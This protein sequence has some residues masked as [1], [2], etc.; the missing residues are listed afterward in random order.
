MKQV[1]LILS[2]TFIVLGCNDKNIKY[3]LPKFNFDEEMKYDVVNSEL[4]L[5]SLILFMDVYKDYLVM[6]YIDKTDDNSWLHIHDKKTGEIIK[7]N[8]L[9]G[10]GPNEILR[11]ES[12]HF[13]HDTGEFSTYIRERS[14][15]MMIQIDSMLAD[16]FE[17]RFKCDS[18]FGLANIEAVCP[19]G[20]NRFVIRFDDVDGYE[21]KRLLMYE[22]GEISGRIDDYPIE[23]RSLTRILYGFSKLPISPDNTKFALGTSSGAILELFDIADG[24]KRTSIGYYYEPIVASDGINVDD[25]A[26][27][28]GFIDLASDDKYVYCA[29]GEPKS[30]TLNNITIFDWS[31]K[32]VKILRTQDYEAMYPIALDR[33]TG[34][35]YTIARAEDGE[36]HIIRIYPF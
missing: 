18:L 25:L 2:V 33:V 4:I 14:E 13:N 8:L 7:S 10:R 12:N 19:V 34:D 28:Y 15:V 22:G 11:P 36:M 20:E 32:P 31:G 16:K 24:I 3:K 5:P 21:Y 27:G 6:V 17:P 26:S 30:E 35:L 9:K 29:S 23:N 1:L